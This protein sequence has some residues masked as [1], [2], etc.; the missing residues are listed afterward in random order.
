MSARTHP[1][2]SE[3]AN[4]RTGAAGRFWK[5]DPRIFTDPDRLIRALA[6]LRRAAV[7]RPISCR[8]QAAKAESCK[9]KGEWG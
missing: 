3:I 7:P 5:P 6:D 4:P 9:V 1:M 2:S 8:F